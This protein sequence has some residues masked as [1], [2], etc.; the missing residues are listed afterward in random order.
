[1]VPGEYVL[2]DGDVELNAGREPARLRVSNSGDRPIQVGS[3]THFFEVNQALQFDRQ[4]AYGR[5]L[6]VPAGTSL[7]FEPGESRDVSLIPLA[8]RRRAYGM[9]ALVNGPL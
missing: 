7:R 9:N 1:M 8:G 5:R 2:Q 6:D 3:H 4:K